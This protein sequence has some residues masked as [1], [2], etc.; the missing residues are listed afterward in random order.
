MRDTGQE[1]GPDA[2]TSPDR[3]RRWGAIGGTLG[4]LYGAGAALIA[5]FVEGAPW[6]PTG[7]YPPFFATPRLLVFDVYMIAALMTGLGFLVSALVFARRGRYPRTDTSGALVLGLVLGLT[8]GAIL[9]ARLAAV[10][11]AG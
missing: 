5:I 1:L 7:A 4:S 6:R 3:E 2:G 9:F 10:A 11:R 8:S